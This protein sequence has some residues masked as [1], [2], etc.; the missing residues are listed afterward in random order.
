MLGRWHFTTVLKRNRESRGLTLHLKMGLALPWLNKRAD[1]VFPKKFEI[2]EFLMGNL[3][4]FFFFFLQKFKTLCRAN[5]PYLDPDGQML[6]DGHQFVTWLLVHIYNYEKR[7]VGI[8]DL[9]VGLPETANKNTE[10]PGNLNFRWKIFVMCKYVSH[11]IRG[12][13][14]FF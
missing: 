8:F 3:H 14:I 7:R 12:M 2:L 5:K 10:C 9:E 6:P 1:P 13:L 4:I 11:N